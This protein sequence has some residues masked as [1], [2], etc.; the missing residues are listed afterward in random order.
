[1]HNEAKTEFQQLCTCLLAY[2]KVDR[3]GHLNW[4]DA[5]GGINFN[6]GRDLAFLS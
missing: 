4:L 2:T 1:M 3:L 5:I 6:I